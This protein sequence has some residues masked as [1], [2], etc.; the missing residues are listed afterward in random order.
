M[1]YLILVRHAKSEWNELGLWTGWTDVSLSKGGRK[2]AKKSAKHLKG[3]PI[4]KTHTSRLKRAIETW[5]ILKDT[6]GLHKTKAVKHKA[7]NEKH[8]GIFTGKNKWQVKEEVGEEI[9]QKIRR[10]WDHPIQGGET[11]KEVHARVVPYY[12]KKI[13]PDIRKGKNVLVVA[14]GNS[15]RP[16]VKYLENLSEEEVEKLEIGIAEIYIYEFDKKGFIVKK[17]I[18]AENK[19]RGKI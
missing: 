1:S 4:H 17:E 7:L 9:F 10:G 2:E 5:E 6:L 14:H 11:L 18:R 16:L 3:F 12:Q 15:L 19:Q 8:Y 13:L